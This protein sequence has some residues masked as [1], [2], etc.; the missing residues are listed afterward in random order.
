MSVVNND[1]KRKHLF[2]AKR[3]ILRARV[4]RLF[5]KSRQSAGARTLVDMLRDEGITLGRFKVERLMK[6]QGLMGKQPS[7]HAYKNVQVERPDIPNLLG[8]QFNVEEANQVWCGGITN[9]WAG[10]SWHYAAVAIEPYTRRVIGWSMSYRSDAGLAARVLDT[11]YELRGKPN[12]VMFH[13]DQGFQ[14]A[15]RK[16]R[17]RL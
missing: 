17:Q 7:K 4:M 10:S 8:I 1:K 6:E 11:A 13:S 2:G 5:D 9:T 3:R 16:L 12:S 14:Y 15:A